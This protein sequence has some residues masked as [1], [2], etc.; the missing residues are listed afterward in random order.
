MRLQGRLARGV[1][2]RPT[3]AIRQVLTSAAA[4][5]GV[6]TS[7]SSFEFLIINRGF[8]CHATTLPS[9]VI[10]VCGP[11]DLRKTTWPHRR[12][13]M[14]YSWRLLAASVWSALR[15]GGGD[16][17]PHF[18]GGMKRGFELDADNLSSTRAAITVRRKLGLSV[19]PSSKDQSTVQRE[20][21]GFGAS[22]WLLPLRFSS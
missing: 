6:I 21:V 17:A 11:W 20:A 2:R 19:S 8:S 10:K 7:V 3:A 16:C 15:G 5:V 9:W 18:G 1:P 14:Q 22:A 13:I 4:C 12:K